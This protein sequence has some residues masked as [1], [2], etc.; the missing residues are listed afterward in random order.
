MVVRQMQAPHK[1]T[2]IGRPN[3]CRSDSDKLTAIIH[4]VEIVTLGLPF[5]GRFEGLAQAHLASRL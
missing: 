1:I 4:Q 2:G 3:L 5:S